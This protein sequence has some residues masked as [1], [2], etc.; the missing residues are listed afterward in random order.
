MMAGVSKSITGSGL[1]AVG[2]GSV[3]GRSGI[4]SAGEAARRLMLEVVISSS[5][6]IGG[7][8]LVEEK[9]MEGA[10][11]GEDKAEIW[12]AMAEAGFNALRTASDSFSVRLS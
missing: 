5:V 6:S 3:G 2:L 11:E 10:R 9:T 7:T 4:S 8:R 1:D 12:S